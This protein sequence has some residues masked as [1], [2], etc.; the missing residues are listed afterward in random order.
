MDNNQMEDLLAEI[1]DCIYH[2]ESAIES[3]SPDSVMHYNGY[4]EDIEAII[5]E[6]NEQKEMLEEK[7]AEAD[8]LNEKYEINA[9]W[10]AVI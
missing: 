4:T 7:L 6:L 5:D 9:Y 2:L 8:A 3:V 1:E 10:K